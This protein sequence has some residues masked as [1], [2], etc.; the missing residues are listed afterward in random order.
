MPRSAVTRRAQRVGPWMDSMGGPVMRP[1]SGVM[2]CR[3]LIASAA[4]GALGV[5]S[6][7]ATGPAVAAPRAPAAANYG[8]DRPTAIAAGAGRLWIAN[9][10]GNSVTETTVNGGF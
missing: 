10:G 1:Q 2:S 4:L 8:F 9:T 5:A 6:I 3:T 7:I